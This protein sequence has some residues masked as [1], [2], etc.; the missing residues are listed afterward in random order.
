M[1]APEAPTSSYYYSFYIRAPPPLKGE[2]KAVILVRRVIQTP[3]A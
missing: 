1:R 2:M 3:A